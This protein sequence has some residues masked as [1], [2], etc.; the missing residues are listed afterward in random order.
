M[1]VRGRAPASQG[2][3]AQAKTDA[4]A[5]VPCHAI[6]GDVARTSRW[7]AHAGQD[8]PGQV[9]VPQLSGAL[10]RRDRPPDHRLAGATACRDTRVVAR[11]QDA[12][13][14]TSPGVKRERS[15][16][17]RAL[18]RTQT[19][20]TSTGS[21]RRPQL[22][23]CAALQAAPRSDSGAPCASAMACAI[24]RPRPAV[25][26]CPLCSAALPRKNRSKTLDRAFQQGS[27]GPVS[28]TSRSIRL[29]RL[30]SAKGG[31]RSRARSRSPPRPRG[32]PD[33]RA[34]RRG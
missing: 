6:V 7:E 22:H 24:A 17:A 25:P 31:H 33:A 10:R 29:Q 14:S 16:S 11:R 2:G 34:A 27:Q 28:Q 5:A 3:R 9:A 8:L 1:S 13:G 15:R 32:D 12:A 18:P 26:A 4:A 19:G 20:F 30:A 23:R 21:S